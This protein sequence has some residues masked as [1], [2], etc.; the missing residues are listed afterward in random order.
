MPQARLREAGKREPRLTCVHLN[1]YT[2]LGLSAVACAATRVR[3][4][5]LERMGR[6]SEPFFLSIILPRKPNWIDCDHCQTSIT[7]FHRPYQID[8]HHHEGQR[9]LRNIRS[10]CISVIPFEKFHRF[11]EKFAW[12]WIGLKHFFKVQQDIHYLVLHSHKQLQRIH[13]YSWRVG[14][15]LKY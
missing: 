13:H 7:L 15:Q 8:C 4:Y 10:E 11:R 5:S 2:Q 9:F 12:I 14:W 1:T 3:R 6:D